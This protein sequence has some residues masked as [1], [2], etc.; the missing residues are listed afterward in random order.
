[1]KKTLLLAALA[2]TS[3]LGVAA[4]NDTFVIDDLLYTVLTETETSKT[5]SVKAPEGDF[6]LSGNVVI[7]DSV[8]NNNIKYAVTQLPYGA[9]KY[10]SD[11]TTISLPETITTFDAGAFLHCSGITAVN[12]NEN[13]PNF[14]SE[15]GVVYN[16][17]MT[18]FIYCP[19]TK[20]GVFKIPETVTTIGRNAF[21]GCEK[22]TG[23]IL[24]DNLTTIGNY[25][26]EQCSSLT[27]IHLPQNAAISSSGDSPFG[28]CSSLEEIT[29]DSE[30]ATLSSVDGVLYNKNITTLIQYPAAKKGVV[31]IPNTVTKLYNGCFSECI[32]L[33]TAHISENL[34][35][36]TGMAFSHCVNL[37]NIEVDDAN[38]SFCSIDGVLYTKDKT[39]LIAYPGGRTGEF[40]IPDFVTKLNGHSFRGAKL[41]ALV[42]PV[43]ISSIGIY[44]FNNCSNL[45]KIIDLNPTPQT[46]DLNSS[47]GTPES[48]TVYVPKGCLDA[49]KQKWQYF[50]NFEEIETFMVALSYTKDN[51]TVGESIKLTA[52]IVSADKTNIEI[53]SEVWSSSIPTVATVDQSGN[54]SALSPGTTTITVTVT[55][56][57]NNVRTDNCLVTVSPSSGVDIISADTTEFIDYSLPF[58]IFNLNGSK[59]G[60]SLTKLQPGVY[61]LRQNNKATKIV[62]K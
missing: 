29:V 2:L 16:K 12:I 7:P 1:M 62:V 20:S 51:L 15:E 50:H 11:I 10:C 41:S 13:N 21:L 36:L 19:N 34:T 57:A 8:T 39:T 24:P 25:C 48:L 18:S 3:L 6:T 30:N 27:S 56:K 23:I 61:I 49:Y 22:L 32:E 54:I 5:V 47:I 40:T 17:N 33:T 58:E 26:F 46:I 38:P 28:F 59:L 31:S 43:S 37:I 45:T 35:T 4:I 52:N 14:C 44:A 42:I 53:A 9:F 55:D 60:G